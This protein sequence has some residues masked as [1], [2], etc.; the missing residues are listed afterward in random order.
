MTKTNLKTLGCKQRK[1]KHSLHKL[2]NTRVFLLV[3]P[4][5]ERVLPVNLC[6]SP[7][8]NFLLISSCPPL[9]WDLVFGAFAF[10]V[11]GDYYQRPP[12]G[13]QGGKLTVSECVE[14]ALGVRE[15]VAPSN[16]GIVVVCFDF[17]EVTNL[18]P[19]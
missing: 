7:S 16:A 18:P 15:F 5:A 12:P 6:L 11:T 13:P 3:V 2:A 1:I 8:S 19:M 9:S 4:L 14:Q 10:C 17:V